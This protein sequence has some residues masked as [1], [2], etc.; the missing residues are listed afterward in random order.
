VNTSVVTGWPPLSRKLLEDLARRY[1]KPLLSFFR[2][3]THNAPEVGDLVQQVFLRLAQYPG[4]EHMHNP[5]GYIFQTAANTLRDHY[6]HQ[7]VRERHSRLVSGREADWDAEFSP[8]RVL[9]GRQTLVRVAD[10]LRQLPERTRDILMLRCFEGLRHAEIAR[11]QGIS[12]RAV[13]KHMAKALAHL[14][15]VLE[16]EGQL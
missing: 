6:R 15:Q 7:A 3:R 5:D 12:T 8:E 11:L 9:Q 13:E 1:Y 16:S 2:K 14:G 10:A 4:L